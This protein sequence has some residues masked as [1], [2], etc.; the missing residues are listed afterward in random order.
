M[1]DRIEEIVLTPP[2]RQLEILPQNLR[3]RNRASAVDVIAAKG[4]QLPLMNLYQRS[5]TASK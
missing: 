5:F 4:T 1:M 3:L 2:F